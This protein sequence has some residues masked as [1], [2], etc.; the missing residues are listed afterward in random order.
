MTVQRS[1]DTR[2][3]NTRSVICECLIVTMIRGSKFLRPDVE[4]MIEI[5]K[6]FIKSKTRVVLTGWFT[7]CAMMSLIGIVMV[8]GSEQWIKLGLLL[9]NIGY[10]YSLYQNNIKILYSGIWFHTMITCLTGYYALFGD[11]KLLP[12]GYQISTPFDTSYSSGILVFVLYMALIIGAIIYVVF[13]IR[14]RKNDSYYYRQKRFQSYYDNYR[15]PYR[16]YC[17]EATSK[18][19]V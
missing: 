12:L 3:E 13:G 8:S 15:F 11:Y 14:K 17:P 6:S 2:T 5:T 7:I 1:G 10:I 4:F 18:R 16:F 19:V 9:L